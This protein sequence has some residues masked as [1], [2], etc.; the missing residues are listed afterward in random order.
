MKKTQM[1]HSPRTFKFGLALI[2]V[3]GLLSMPVLTG[4]SERAEKK[5][6]AE[7]AKKAEASEK[8]SNQKLA[9]AGRSASEKPTTESIKKRLAS[10]KLGAETKKTSERVA[11]IE[12]EVKKLAAKLTPT[13]KTKLLAMLNDAKSSDLTKIDGIGES[14]SQAIKQARPIESVED[15]RRVKGLGLKTLAEVIDHGMSLTKSK[16]KSSSKAKKSTKAAKP[17]T[18]QK[19]KA[20]A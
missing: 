15:L 5:A 4:A 16:S 1:I 3:A 7:M 20:K 12:S 8:R 11:K 18:S 2:L 6:N 14:R 9:D 13:Q 17:S 19:S 10:A